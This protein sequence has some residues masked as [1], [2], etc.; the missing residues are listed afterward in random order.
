[1]SE[2]LQAARLLIVD[3]NVANSCLLSNILNRLGFRII[4]STTDSRETFALVES[5]QPDLILLDL[6]TPHLDGVAVMQRLTRT[7]PRDNFLPV[8]VLTSETSA[9]TVSKA[10]A[11]GASDYQARPFNTSELYMRVRN[12]L[13]IRFLHRQLQDQ[14]ET[15]EMKV[16]E[17][18]RELHETQQ[19]IIA[20]ERLRAFGEMAGGIVHD[21]NNALMSVIGYSELLLQDQ[22]LLEDLPTARR[23]LTIM[24]TAGQD[25]SHVISRRKT[26]TTSIPPT[27]PDAR[28][29]AADKAQSPR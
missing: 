22:N 29:E 20:Q 25:A 23:F 14:N 24:N 17:R 16:A 4:K 21:F 28:S 9:E 27:F 10:L 15:L 26:R 1:M 19:Q 18:T 7:I 13:Q 8:L 3:N 2:M 11:A 5:F 12:L 6:N